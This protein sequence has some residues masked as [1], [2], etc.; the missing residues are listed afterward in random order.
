MK[1]QIHGAHGV[2]GSYAADL[3]SFGQGIRLAYI[4]PYGLLVT[5]GF[6]WDV[7][8][9]DIDWEAT[10]K[11]SALSSAVLVNNPKRWRLEMYYTPAGGTANTKALYFHY[12]PSHAKASAG[13]GF[14]TKITGPINA[15]ATSAMVS[16]INGEYYV[17]TGNTDGV[18][19][20]EDVGNS[21]A[22]AAGGITW[23]CFT[24]DIY[25]GGIGF[26]SNMK[27]L[28]V[29]HAASTGQTGTVNVVQRLEGQNDTTKTQDISLTRREHTKASINA[30]GDAMQLGITNS[31]SSGQVSIDFFAADYDPSG[32]SNQ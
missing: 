16:T 22:S 7:L 12:H 3:F 25:Q 32:R 17:F 24:G 1:E 20:Q 27:R 6:S 28:W 21:D 15:I 2:V 26:Q 30:Y 13:G 11:V 8:T 19:Y 18:A 29:H 23:K 31:D 10:V 14:R 5:D 9:D 4:S